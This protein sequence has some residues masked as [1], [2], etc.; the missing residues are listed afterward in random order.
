MELKQAKGNTWYLEDWQ[1]IPLYKVDEHH[2]ILLDSGLYEQ[3][4]DL[5]RA[6]VQAG[7]TPIG[8]LGSHAHN[9]HS[10]NHH[11]FQQKYRIPVALPMGEAA[12]CCSMANLKGYFFMNSMEELRGNQRV[13]HMVV[14]PDRIIWP[15][16]E[17]ITFCGVDFQILHTPGHSPDHICVGT[18]DGVLYLAD[19]LLTGEELTHAK[20]PFHFCFQEAF[21]SLHRLQTTQA[22]LYLAAHR[23]VYPHLGDLPE[24]NIRRIRERAEII[25]KLID[26]PIHLS[27]V[28]R[29]VCAAFH[30]RSSAKGAVALYERNTRSYL[31]YL[32]DEG[33]IDT[34]TRDGIFYYAP[35]QGSR[36]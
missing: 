9:D 13:S 11:Y 30:L 34:V 19:A 24:Q 2:C 33:L 25:A 23:G 12:L 27:E 6:L 18:P 36:P 5:E 7:L 1:L 3:R 17:Q 21:H 4:Q 35:K 29:R 20:L 15:E 28:S 22:E 14:R 31:E 8:I 10:S 26:A 32:R 16:E